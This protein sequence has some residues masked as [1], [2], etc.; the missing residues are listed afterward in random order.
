MLLDELEACDGLVV[1]DG[2]FSDEVPQGYGRMFGAYL[3]EF[4]AEGKIALKLWGCDAGEPPYPGWSAVGAVD[5]RT[6]FEGQEA[7]ATAL[8][9]ILQGTANIRICGAWATHDNSSGCA[10]SVKTAM[11]AAGICASR[12]AMSDSC[13]FE[14]DL[15]A[16]EDLDLGDEPFS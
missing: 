8:A 3:E 7:V 5:G 11:E 14:E 6:V 12:I 1:I 16:D 13:I 10:S 9:G 4:E 15:D 2:M